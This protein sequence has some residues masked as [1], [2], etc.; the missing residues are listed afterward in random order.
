M[1]KSDRWLLWPAVASLVGVTV[2][3]FICGLLGLISFLIIPVAVFSLPIVVIAIGALA[4]YLLIKQNPRKATS[5]SFA[6]IL[7]LVLLSPINWVAD[8]FHLGVT[9]WLGLGHLGRAAKPDGHGLEVFDWSVGLAG[10]PNTFLIRDPTD[11]IALSGIKIAD[12]DDPS[13]FLEGCANK[14]HHLLGHYYICDIDW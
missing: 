12:L 4:I 14:T 5:L 13:G 1:P 3:A 8:C 6:L 11:R 2:M 9:A 10:G 7:P